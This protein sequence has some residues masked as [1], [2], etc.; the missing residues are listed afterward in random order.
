MAQDVSTRITNRLATPRVVSSKD[1]HGSKGGFIDT[2]EVSN[3]ADADTAVLGEAIPLE[4][5]I[6]SVRIASDDLGSAGVMDV[7]L[8][9]LNDAGVVV[10]VDADCFA[11]GLDVNA[12][13]VAF[14][15]RRFTALNID[16][17]GKK[18]WELCSGVTAK[19]TSYPEFFLLLTFTTGTTAAGTVSAIVEWHKP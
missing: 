6:T 3:N 8:G 17:A 1:P 2:I 14:T 19:P 9:Y 12:A 18:A 15:E 13:A 7:G 4:A 5:S 11:S 16:T 10:A